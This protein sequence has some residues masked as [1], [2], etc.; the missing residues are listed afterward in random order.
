M[1]NILILIGLFV[2]IGCSSSKIDIE[3]QRLAEAKSVDFLSNKKE[4]KSNKFTFTEAFDEAYKKKNVIGEVIKAG[5]AGRNSAEV[6][7]KEFDKL[8]EKIIN[9]DEGSLSLQQRGDLQFGIFSALVSLVIP[10]N[11]ETYAAK[12]LNLMIKNSE[13]IQWDLLGQ[14]YDLAE[15]TLSDKEKTKITSY[16]KKGINSMLKSNSLNISKPVYETLCLKGK[17]VLAT[18]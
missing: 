2:F 6:G 12:Y 18:M 8:F 4:T 17:E 7:L 9:G 13:P 10:T 5:F 14:A 1:K 16:M 3:E 11:N 15:P